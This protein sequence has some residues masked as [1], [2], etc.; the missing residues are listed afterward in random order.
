MTEPSTALA[1]PIFVAKLYSSAINNLSYPMASCGK[2]ILFNASSMKTTVL[3]NICCTE[4]TSTAYHI[5]S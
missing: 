2:V 4:F 1:V 5:T 3:Q